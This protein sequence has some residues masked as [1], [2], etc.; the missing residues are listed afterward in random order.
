MLLN[1][2]IISRSEQE[3]EETN[4]TYDQ[5]DSAVVSA[6]GEEEARL[7]KPGKRGAW[8]SIKYVDVK[9]ICKTDMTESKVIHTQYDYP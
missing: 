5:Y 2:Y 9:F 6:K 7:M 8:P 1:L 4:N 3:S